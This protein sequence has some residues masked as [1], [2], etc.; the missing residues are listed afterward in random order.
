MESKTR[1]FLVTMLTASIALRLGDTLNL[2]VAKGTA[3]PVTKGG[4]SQGSC[5]GSSSSLGARSQGGL[6]FLTPPAFFLEPRDAGAGV[7]FSFCY[8]PGAHTRGGRT[9]FSPC[10]C[11]SHVSIGASLSRIKHSRSV[12]RLRGAL[13]S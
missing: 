8:F 12:K 10:S 13:P 5:C 1:T 4:S 7:R 2:S 6:V 3:L 9:C 11:L